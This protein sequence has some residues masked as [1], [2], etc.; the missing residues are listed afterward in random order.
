MLMSGLK[1]EIQDIIQ[2]AIDRGDI[3]GAN[4][5]VIKDDEELCQVTLGYSKLEEK[6]PLR[7]DNI[8]RLYSMTKPVTAAALMILYDRGMLRLD[9][10]IEKYIPEFAE[11]MVANDDGTLRRADKA[12][13]IFDLL[14]MTSGIVYPDVWCESE[15][16]MKELFDAAREK[17]DMGIHTDTLEYCRQIAK[18][19]L[20]FEPGAKW[21]YGLSADIIGG[22]IEVVTGKALSDFYKE[23]IFEPLGMKDTGFILSEEQRK[24]LSACY[25]YDEEG[26]L[27]IYE[28]NALGLEGYTEDTVFFSGGAGLVSTMDDYA[29]FAKMML[30]G[31]SYEGIRIL[32]EE[33]VRLIST[34]HL[35]SEQAKDYNWESLAGYGYGF[36]V[37]V[38]TEPE[39]TGNGGS[40]GEYGWDGW[41]GGYVAI[42]PAE[43]MILLYF[44]QRTCAGTTDE[45]R[46]IR[47]V[48]HTFLTEN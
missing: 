34:N 24:R 33:A 7:R 8:F 46:K 27:V 1:D 48:L 32:S 18:C 36:L 23:E 30:N 43:N 47:R 19:P 38:L 39:K 20:C 9:D 21:K 13:T 44:I 35:T 28:D 17:L 41:T 29:R 11:C 31:G 2:S 5:L 42:A 16:R 6:V 25:Q 14:T 12:I 22:I 40:V 15:L 4:M 10:K 45:V 26:R 37:R 3:A